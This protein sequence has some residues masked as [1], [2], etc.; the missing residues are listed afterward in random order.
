MPSIESK[1][2]AL[3]SSALVG[4]SLS[5]FEVCRIGLWSC[6]PLRGAWIVQG[7]ATPMLII[8]CFTPMSKS[9]LGAV[10]VVAGIGMFMLGFQSAHSEGS[11]TWP[12]HM[13]MLLFGGSVAALAIMDFLTV[14]RDRFV[15]PPLIQPTPNDSCRNL[16]LLSLKGKIF[17]LYAGALAGGVLGQ[18]L[19]YGSVNNRSTFEYDKISFEDIPFLLIFIVGG[20]ATPIVILLSQLAMD[21]VTAICCSL[22]VATLVLGFSVVYG[23]YD[24]LFGHN[25]LGYNV[26]WFASILAALTALTMHKRRL[27]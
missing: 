16:Q 8:L 27:L 13:V 14:N 1:V 12:A 5:E 26:L 3:Y 23:Q 2:V 15:P 17:Y 10:S 21:K 18:I 25:G 6:E 19:I 22:V 9:L 4:A 24:S 7:P 20:S 11:L